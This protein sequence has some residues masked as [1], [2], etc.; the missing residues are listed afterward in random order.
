PL[1]F[2][3]V[4]LF[5]MAAQPALIVEN[6]VMYGQ[7][8][9][10]LSQS[11][12]YQVFHGGTIESIRIVEYD[13]LSNALDAI[14]AG[15]ADMLGHE[16]NAS[17]Y[18]LVDGYSNIEQQWAY[19][20][21]A[22]LLSLDASYYPLNDY[23][24][25]KAIAYAVDKNKIAETIMDNKVDPIDFAMPL[26]SEY[27]IEDTEGGEFYNA[28]ISRGV[29]ELALAGML[30]VDQDTVVEGP[31]GS[32]IAIPLLYPIEI[33]GMNE[34]ANQISLDLI[35]I[36]LNNTLVPMNFVSLQLLISNHTQKYG[37]ALYYQELGIY[38]YDWIATTFHVFGR[39][40]NGE[41]IANINDA[42]LNELAASYLNQII[43]SEA[44]RVG[45]EAMLRVRALCPIVPLFAYRILSVYTEEN[46]ENW[47]EDIL[48]GILGAWS[49]ISISAKSGSSNELVVAV[50]PTYFDEFFKSLNPFY[51]NHTIGP[52]WTDGNVFNPYLLVYD[53]PI[54]TSPEGIPVARHATSWEMQFLG[55]VPDLS[56]GQSRASFYCDPNANW[57]D[58]QQFDA[59]DYRFTFEYY[60]NNSLTE[61]QWIDSIKIT[62]EFVA[63]I[64][65]N[66]ED[67]FLYK[68]LGALP[69]LPEHIWEGKNPITWNPGL[70]D[71][72][73]SGP[74]MFSEF[75]PGS[76]IVLVAN[77][78]YY[79][80]MD[81][82]PPTLRVLSIVPEEP[83]PTESVVFRVFVDDRSRIENVTISYTY[84]VGT[85]N[86][87]DSQQMIADASG[88]EATIPARVT[89]RAVAWQIY[90]TDVWG[91]TAL[92][93][94]GEY[95]RETIT[96]VEGLDPNLIL[97]LEVSG[98]VFLVL[99]VVVLIRRRRK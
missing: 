48:R 93:A 64:T 16:V 58:G 98:A 12:E 13:S 94:E 19:D 27:S 95:S 43:L 81:T 9:M 51:G 18:A 24:L 88:F 25:R 63:G 99:L 10:M 89:A 7:S 11:E 36:G 41:N 77:D 33:E 65:Y 52:E 26:Y 55:I 86:F 82:E 66:Q 57:T 40:I 56:N 97:A 45:K 35:A 75:T 14:D 91:N 62:G 69:I 67:M 2:L 78:E 22:M 44:E 3:C 70:N 83:I 38:G 71:A 60:R 61:Y 46:F 42:S 23:H 31:D 4:I 30:D 79:P 28:N 72:I 21:G 37:M 39:S 49:P 5:S 73:G 54:A 20:N 47:P 32:E 96:G 76:E 85:I 34:T 1:V 59:N 29:H 68:R 74:F 6:P 92:I 8:N 90:A 15:T 80:E 50:L 84:V 87:T 17:D 53:S